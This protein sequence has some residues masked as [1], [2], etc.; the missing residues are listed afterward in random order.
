MELTAPGTR[1]R[2]NSPSEAR[3]RALLAV[4]ALSSARHMRPSLAAPMVTIAGRSRSLREYSGDDD[5]NGT[6]PIPTNCS[7][8]GVAEAYGSMLRQLALEP[9]M[10]NVHQ[11]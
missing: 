4:A 6:A 1:K 11:I 9:G 5:R 7:P 2:G 8:I 3:A 10:A